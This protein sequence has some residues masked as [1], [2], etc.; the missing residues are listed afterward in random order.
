[1]IRLS[2]KTIWQSLI[3]LLSMFVCM[4]SVA[5]TQT[6]TAEQR[7]LRSMKSG[8]QASVRAALDELT[9]KALKNGKAA[10]VVAPDSASQSD[11]LGDR[12]RPRIITIDYPGAVAT[13]LVAINEYQ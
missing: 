12:Q 4:C 9:H 5:R 2:G 3:T 11:D 6:T 8:N 13:L 7:L 10:S 1:M